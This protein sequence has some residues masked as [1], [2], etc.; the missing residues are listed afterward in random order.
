MFSQSAV[1]GEGTGMPRLN[2]EASAQQAF[3]TGMA[4]E[5]KGDF[6]RALVYFKLATE[7]MPNQVRFIEA[8]AHVFE[9][10]G[11]TSQATEWYLRAAQV[12]DDET[13]P[14]HTKTKWA[15]D[16]LVERAWLQSLQP[17]R[18]G[19]EDVANSAEH[20]ERLLT[21]FGPDAV[22]YRKLALL[23]G[24]LSRIREATTLLDEARRA[25]LHELHW[26]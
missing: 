12:Q 10:M 23:L 16:L 14:Q 5:A 1:A 22:A 26:R 8:V 15:Y 24:R 4:F 6:K 7:N 20:L 9:R 11:K 19:Q 21:H 13:N 2:I 25:E 3:E 17:N 18:I